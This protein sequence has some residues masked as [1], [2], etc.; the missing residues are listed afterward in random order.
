MGAAVGGILGAIV[1]IPLFASLQI[2]AKDVVQR[3]LA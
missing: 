3:H 1:A 2:V